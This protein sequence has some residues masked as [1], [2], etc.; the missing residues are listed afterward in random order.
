[1]ADACGECLRDES[2]QCR[3]HEVVALKYKLDKLQK[4]AEDVSTCYGNQGGYIY[5]QYM[6]KMREALPDPVG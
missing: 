4:A 2:K 1:M 6:S 5:P 3:R